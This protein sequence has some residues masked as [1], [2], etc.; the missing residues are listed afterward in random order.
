MDRYYLSKS[1][2]YL[3]YLIPFFLLIGPALPDIA[4]VISVFLVTSEILY[5][6][7]FKYFNNN[8]FKFFLI[9]YIYLVL[10]SF[11][12]NYP[13]TSLQTSLPYLRFIILPIIIWYLLDTHKNFLR[14]FFFFL[15]IAY[16]IGLFSGV[17]QLIFSQTLF[18]VESHYNRMM[19]LASDNALLGHY[20]ARL[21]P[22]IIG[23]F[24][25]FFAYK[26]LHYL[27]LLLI[28]VMSDIV[29]YLSGER[30]ALGLIILSSTFIIIFMSKFKILRISALSFSLII[31]VIISILSPSIKERNVDMTINQMGLSSESK[32]VHMFSPVHDSLYKTSI[33]IFLDNPVFGV[34]PNNFRKVCN[35]QK[36]FVNQY[37][38]S[39]HPHNTFI[40]IFAEIG[41]V[42][43][44]F[45]LMIIFY[46]LKN[47]W[48]H[49][50]SILK[51]KSHHLND[52]QVCLYA[53]F[54]LFLFPLLP[55][56]NFFTNWIN[57][58]NYLP[59]GFYL[60]TIYS[61]KNIYTKS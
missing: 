20:L 5:L 1:G 33:K 43:L 25:Y 57:I 38:C 11:F 48:Y 23:L 18:G 13:V 8:Y 61:K 9:F 55:T 4:L 59:V 45:I 51:N 44:L 17:Y 47:V 3:I 24:I 12:S 46:L 10:N 30:T 16:L 49:L 56:L 52:F 39:T 42:G 6:K 15:T 28:F 60:Y 58:I 29:I 7:N 2:S 22:L 40:Q 27:M 31:I 14:N 35:N 53:C 36:Y 41:I 32:E 50:L 37:S 26:K 21:F 34:G 54:L 19:L